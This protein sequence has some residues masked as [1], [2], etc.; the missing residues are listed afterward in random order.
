MG[1]RIP[2]D[3]FL[4]TLRLEA[5]CQLVAMSALQVAYRRQEVVNRAAAGTRRAA[6][7]AM[8]A[9]SFRCAARRR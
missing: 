9:S 6:V 2:V 7:L 3:A 4:P 1:T 5:N 8:A